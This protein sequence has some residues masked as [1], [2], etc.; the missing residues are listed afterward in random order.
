MHTAFKYTQSHLTALKLYDTN[1]DAR[2]D[3]TC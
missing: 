2:R 1:T 3:A